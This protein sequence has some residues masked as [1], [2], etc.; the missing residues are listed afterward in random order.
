VI[1]D[2]LFDCADEIREYLSGEPHVYAEYR[3]EIDEILARMDNLRRQLDT[4]PGSELV[5]RPTPRLAEGIA[6]E[7]LT[8]DDCAEIADGIEHFIMNGDANV[9]AIWQPYVDKL[10]AAAARK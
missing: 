4:L 1:S 8:A 10:K 6:A 9:D 7:Q 2:V 5:A 3:A